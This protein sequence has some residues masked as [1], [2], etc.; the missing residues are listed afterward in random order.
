MASESKGTWEHVSW[1]RQQAEGCECERCEAPRTGA[2]AKSAGAAG[3]TPE[4]VAAVAAE[5]ARRRNTPPG[6]GWEA[7]VAVMADLMRQA[8]ARQD[9]GAVFE[10]KGS[11]DGTGR[12]AIRR[13]VP[14]ED[15]PFWYGIGWLGE[16]TFFAPVQMQAQLCTAFR[17][18]PAGLAL[19]VIQEA[20]PSTRT[21]ALAQGAETQADTELGERVQAAFD[22]DLE[23]R[24][25]WLAQFQYET[26]A[27]LKRERGDDW[28]GLTCIRRALE[29]AEREVAK[30]REQHAGLDAYYQ[31]QEEA[32]RP[33][34][35]AD[36]PFGEAEIEAAQARLQEQ[37]AEL[38][39]ALDR[40]KEH[41]AFLA[42]EREHAW[43]L[44][45]E[46]AE[47]RDAR[48]NALAAVRELK[49]RVADLE[50]QVDRQALLIQ[51]AEQ[52]R[53]TGA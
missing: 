51:A 32:E 43:A 39:K 35:I 48:D 36:N 24:N 3:H 42:A 18:Y 16:P 26:L 9:Y 40:L 13:P 12:Y 52:G 31:A 8:E 38:H 20:A 47:T 4:D 33:E 23:R 50:A 10:L 1:D 25:Q 45:Q 46:L 41:R 6:P 34:I 28:S 27:F 21:E 14:L 11:W 29:H 22:A 30:T 53:R 19:E 15:G 37:H 44:R 5:N 49:G 7:V 2:P 17:H